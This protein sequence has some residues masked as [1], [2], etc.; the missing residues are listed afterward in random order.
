MAQK[1][2][3]PV[4]LECYTTDLAPKPVGKRAADRLACSHQTTYR[5]QTAILAAEPSPKKGS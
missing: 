1:L 5:H 2:Y 4:C 3:R